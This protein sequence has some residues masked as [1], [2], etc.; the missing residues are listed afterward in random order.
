[1]VGSYWGAASAVSSN[2]AVDSLVGEGAPDG[3]AVGTAAKIVAVLAAAA[4]ATASDRIRLAIAYLFR[5]ISVA[6]G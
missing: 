2:L 6:G 1:M 5:C 3:A 4:V